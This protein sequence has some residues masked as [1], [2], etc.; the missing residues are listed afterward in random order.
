MAKLK[1]RE[2]WPLEA[3]TAA[4]LEGWAL[5]DCDGVTEIQRIDEPDNV[6]WELKE[7]DKLVNEPHVPQLGSDAAAVQLVIKKA[8]EGSLFHLLALYLDGRPAD[9][10]PYIPSFLR[11]K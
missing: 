9:A 4:K 7:R 1:K 6:A 8:R 5:F 11:F 3:D 2:P 10:R